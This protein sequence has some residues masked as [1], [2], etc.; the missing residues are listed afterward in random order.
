[1]N[2]RLPPD[3]VVLDAARNALS[4]ARDW[5]ASD[6][7]DAID[8]HRSPETARIISRAVQQIGL[9]KGSIDAAKDAARRQGGALSR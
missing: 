4:D 7:T 1:M 5:L 3:L 9:A 6:T 8:G 2:G